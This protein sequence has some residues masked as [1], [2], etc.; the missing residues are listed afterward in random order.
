MKLSVVIAIVFI[1]LTNQNL[2]GQDNRRFS[3]SIKLAANFA[4][5]DGDLISGY[6]RFGYQAGI[7]VSARINRISELQV[8]FLYNLRGSRF[9]KYDPPTI[10]YKL[11][12]IDIP[13]LYSIKDWLK[14]DNKGSYY[15][16]HFQGGLYLGRLIN[17]SGLDPTIEKFKKN[18]F[19]WIL[20][21]SYYSSR[22]YGFYARFTRSFIPLYT[23]HNQDGEKINMISYFISLGLTYKFN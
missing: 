10:A 5:I 2:K 22:H 1:G 19:G 13:V 4:Q 21:A 7:G 20:G 8:E 14:E 17:S 9:G 15:R 3:G 18:D 12:Y 6:N 16:T 11:G 23:Y